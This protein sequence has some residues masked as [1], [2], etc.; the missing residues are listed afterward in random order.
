MFPRPPVCYCD[1][2]RTELRTLRRVPGWLS[3]K[4]TQLFFFN[5]GFM[6]ERERTH[7]HASEWGRGEG[8]SQADAALFH[9]KATHFY[10]P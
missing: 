7:V 2:I 6:R 9:V 3:G 4:S 1:H 5:Q 10:W 8:E